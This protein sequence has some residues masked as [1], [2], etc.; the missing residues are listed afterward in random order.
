MK[1]EK[2]QVG[3]EALS[4]LFT[5]VCVTNF[6]MCFLWKNAKKSLCC[7]VLPMLMHHF[8][9]HC[10]N[11]RLKYSTTHPS[12][13]T[14][15]SQTNNQALYNIFLSKILQC[16]LSLI[17]FTTVPTID[18]NNSNNNVCNKTQASED[19]KGSAEWIWARSCQ[20]GNWRPEVPW[21]FLWGCSCTS[22]LVCDL[23]AWMSA[24]WWTI[25]PS[26]LDPFFKQYPTLMLLVGQVEPLIQKFR[27]YVHPFIAAIEI[28]ILLWEDFDCMSFTVQKYAT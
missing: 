7:F 25:F 24:R 21:I 27:N 10:K 16:N 23:G 26:H 20:R 18:I 6:N 17:T 13:T 9:E 4:Y 3:L 19:W 8:F 5:V 15:C 28:W 22:S 11:P 1:N 14:I 2:C 12:W